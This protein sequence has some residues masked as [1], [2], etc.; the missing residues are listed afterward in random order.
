MIEFK[1]KIEIKIKTTL[2][3]TEDIK[4]IISA[5]ENIVKVKGSGGVSPANAKT[6]VRLEEAKYAQGWYDSITNDM[7]G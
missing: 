6:S 4:S 7:F 5:I 3:K 1:N 2:N